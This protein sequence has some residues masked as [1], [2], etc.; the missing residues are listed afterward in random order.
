MDNLE[1]LKKVADATVQQPVEFEVD[2]MPQNFIQRKLQEW[3]I[4]PKKRIFTIRPIVLGNLI[5]ISKILLSIDMNVFNEANLLESN[6]K[7][8]ELHADDLVKIVAIGIQNTKAEP[9]ARLID[10]IKTQFSAVEFW[11]IVLLIRSQMHVQHFMNTIISVR[12]LN[13]LDKK[14][15]KNGKQEVSPMSQGS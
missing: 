14:E 6:Y 3:G 15:E 8:M 1:T 2:I 12:G 13:V 5:R 4:R 9:S 10:L 7:M 11:N